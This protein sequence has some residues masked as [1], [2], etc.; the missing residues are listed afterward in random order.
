MKKC[1]ESECSD[2]APKRVTSHISKRE[3]N[4]DDNLL[5]FTEENRTKMECSLCK[6]RQEELVDF[7]SEISIHIHS[8]QSN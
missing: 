2:Q 6:I 7:N 1:M 3:G 5:Y 4:N 8:T